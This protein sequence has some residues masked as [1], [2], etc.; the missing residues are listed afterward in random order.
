MV[1]DRVQ[2]LS[3]D[4]PGH[5]PL[6]RQGPA[7]PERFSPWLWTRHAQAGWFGELELRARHW[8]FAGQVPFAI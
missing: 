2:R 6:S 7:E 5:R 8:I 1:P 3:E 4:S